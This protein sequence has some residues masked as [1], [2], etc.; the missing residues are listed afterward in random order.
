MA[1]MA[2]TQRMRWMVRTDK[3]V[4]AAAAVLLAVII[5]M[6]LDHMAILAK[7]VPAA[8]PCVCT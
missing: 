5:E 3:T 7:A 2:E 1:E 8:L 6:A 4:L